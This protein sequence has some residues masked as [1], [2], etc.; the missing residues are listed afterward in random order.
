MWLLYHP[1]KGGGKF[2]CKKVP[3]MLQLDRSSTI[4]GVRTYSVTNH[5]PA[6]YPSATNPPSWIVPFQLAKDGEVWYSLRK[7]KPLTFLSE[8]LRP[9]RVV[10]EALVPDDVAGEVIATEKVLY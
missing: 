9:L 1:A 2:I 6:S 10:G 7:D 8:S 3:Q 4:A 5:D